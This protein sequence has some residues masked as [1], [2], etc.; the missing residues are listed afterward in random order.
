MIDSVVSALNTVLRGNPEDEMLIKLVVF[1]TVLLGAVALALPF[2][3]IYSERHGDHIR[4]KAV[5]IV[6][7]LS[8][9]GS[10]MIKWN[11]DGS[12][13]YWYAESGPGKLVAVGDIHDCVK[14]RPKTTAWLFG[15]TIGQCRRVRT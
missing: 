11:C 9:A 14:S 12:E 5:D 4:C 1:L 6:P 10:P 13:E 3:M 2:D 8:A 7:S 15:P